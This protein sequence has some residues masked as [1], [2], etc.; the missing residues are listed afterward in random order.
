MKIELKKELVEKQV[1]SSENGKTL[2]NLE[3]GTFIIKKS[4]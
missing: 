2:F 1:L 3:S 4:Q